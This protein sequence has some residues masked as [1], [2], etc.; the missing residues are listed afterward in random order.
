MSRPNSGSSPERSAWPSST[1]GEG[2]RGCREVS[3][4]AR[5]GGGI[6]LVRKRWWPRMASPSPG[7]AWVQR[8][9]SQ[10]RPKESSKTI[11]SV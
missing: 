6:K 2:H 10:K 7:Q 1:T 9:M 11:C 4:P 5:R 3:S 8:V